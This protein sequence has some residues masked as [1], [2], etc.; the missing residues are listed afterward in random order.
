M[1]FPEQ[2]GLLIAVLITLGLLSFLVKTIFQRQRQTHPQVDI[3]KFPRKVKLP[4]GTSWRLSEPK[5][6]QVMYQRASLGPSETRC[7]TTL[8][9]QM[10]EATRVFHA[11]LKPP[12]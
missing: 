3:S 9:P 7:W 1:S 4:D 11:H 6:G 5:H 2:L 10:D 8:W 12:P